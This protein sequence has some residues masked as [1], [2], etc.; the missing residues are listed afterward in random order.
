MDFWEASVTRIEFDWIISGKGNPIPDCSQRKI[1]F[2]WSNNANC[3]SQYKSAVYLWIIKFCSVYV[4][5]GCPFIRGE[6]EDILKTK[7]FL[8]KVF[9]IM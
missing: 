2:I 4:L 9:K 7:K 5:K 8:L 1:F 6:R 3:C